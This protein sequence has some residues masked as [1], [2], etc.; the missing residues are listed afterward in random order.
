MLFLHQN[1]CVHGDLKMSNIMID[2]KRNVRLVDFGYSTLTRSP[3]EK[4]SNYSGTPAYIAPEII[5]KQPYNGSPDQAS[6]QTCG[7]WECS[8]T[9]C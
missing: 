2:S 7:R 1:N 4:I 9:K 3:R 6:R 5:R 8:S